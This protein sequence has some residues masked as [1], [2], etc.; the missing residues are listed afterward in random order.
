MPFDLTIKRSKPEKPICS[1]CRSDQVAFDEVEY[2][3][4][5]RQVLDKYFVDGEVSC[6]S[7]GGRSEADWVLE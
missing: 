4:E 7:C 1:I 3:D 5:E 6:K 2:W